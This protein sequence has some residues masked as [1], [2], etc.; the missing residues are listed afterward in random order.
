MQSIFETPYYK[1]NGV[2]RHDFEMGLKKQDMQHFHAWLR[3]KRLT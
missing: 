1:G 2:I 3:F